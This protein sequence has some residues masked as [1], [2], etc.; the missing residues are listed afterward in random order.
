MVD[1]DFPMFRF[2]RYL[3]DGAAAAARGGVRVVRLALL[4]YINAPCKPYGDENT[5]FENWVRGKQFP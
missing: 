5:T 2:G 1:T 3:P 4:K